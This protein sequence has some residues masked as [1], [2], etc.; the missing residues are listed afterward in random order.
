MRPTFATGLAVVLLGAS[1]G[2]GGKGSPTSAPDTSTPPP[3]PPV[4][5]RPSLDGTYLLTESQMFGQK[6]TAAEIAKD[7]EVER[8]YVIKGN[9]ITDLF[10]R[11]GKSQS[12]KLD[13]SKTPHEIDI[14]DP[15]D[16]GEAKAIR[17]IY[18]LEGDKLTI[19]LGDKKPEER[20]R[21]FNF[22]GGNVI[23]V[24]VKKSPDSGSKEPGGPSSGGVTDS[25]PDGP[26]PSGPSVGGPV[27]VTAPELAKLYAEDQ[28]KFDATYKGKQVIV[29]GEVHSSGYDPFDKK[30]WM[31]LKG[32]KGPDDLVETTV[33]FWT[34]KEFEGLKA[35]D[36][37]R[38]RGTVVGFQKAILAAELKDP[39]LE[40]E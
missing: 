27:K 5:G 34:T 14:F 38:M 36:R 26:K 29:T 33:R 40:K 32:F 28:K 22:G 24:L 6:Q 16:G 21:D 13:A 11:K 35:G 3:A 2:C 7:P 9:V 15:K 31:M 12:I 25:K 23:L 19:A 17:G 37:V 18:K 8:T 4:A 10:G 1:F 20:P 39:K 30:N